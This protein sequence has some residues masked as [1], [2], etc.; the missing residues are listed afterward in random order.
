MDFDA[1]LSRRRALVNALLTVTLNR[2]RQGART[3]GPEAVTIEW[4]L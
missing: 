2:I 1:T 3:F 4:R